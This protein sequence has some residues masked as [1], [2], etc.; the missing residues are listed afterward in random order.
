V[1]VESCVPDKVAKVGHPMA[2][3]KLVIDAGMEASSLNAFLIAEKPGWAMYP[4]GR[5]MGLD[6]AGS[7]AVMELVL[8]G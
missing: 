7:G 6:C 1:C 4:T 2:E 5:S 3:T 8:V